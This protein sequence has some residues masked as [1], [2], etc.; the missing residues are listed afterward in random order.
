MKK[1][2]QTRGKAMRAHY[3]YASGGELAPL[4]QS[5]DDDPLSSL[6]LSGAVLSLIDCTLPDTVEFIHALQFGR[7]RPIASS[8]AILFPKHHTA[9]RGSSIGCS[10]KEVFLVAKAYFL[11]LVAV[12]CYI[13][14]P[15]SASF[16]LS[17]PPLSLFASLTS[18][19]D[20]HLVLFCTTLAFHTTLNQ[21]SSHIHLT[22]TPCLQSTTPS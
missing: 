20:T 22:R 7:T 18:Y 3:M 1:M 6:P 17:L 19:T 16:S 8:Q 2:K 12:R 13:T 11:T 10:G 15:A 9:C 5:T 14:Y 4:C 21:C